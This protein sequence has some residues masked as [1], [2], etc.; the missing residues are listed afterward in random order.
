MDSIRESIEHVVE[1]RV[2]EIKTRW[3]GSG[4]RISIWDD[5][6]RRIGPS[7]D[8]ALETAQ[9]AEAFNLSPAVETLVQAARDDLDSGRVKAGGGA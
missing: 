9:D 5:R 4:W 1:G 7:Y 3:I 6:Q 8:V 2:Y